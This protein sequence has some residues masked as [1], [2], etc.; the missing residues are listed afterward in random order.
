[1]W[2]KGKIIKISHMLYLTKW[3]LHLFPSPIPTISTLEDTNML[4][5]VTYLC[6]YM[7]VCKC[8]IDSHVYIFCMTPT[9]ITCMS[10]FAYVLWLFESYLFITIMYIRKENNRYAN[11]LGDL[12]ICLFQ[13]A[14]SEQYII[15]M[16]TIC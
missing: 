9:C 11:A 5:N 14:C 15:V 3:R 6:Q 7:S 2:N 4:S 12:Y 16:L 10:K 1:M 13:Y 8:L